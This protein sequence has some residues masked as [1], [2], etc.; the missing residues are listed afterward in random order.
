MHFF[1]T[2][3][4]HFLQSFLPSPENPKDSPTSKTD[5]WK[6][7]SHSQPTVPELEI[8]PTIW[9]SETTKDRVSPY[10]LRGYSDPTQSISSVLSNGWVTKSDS[11]KHGLITR[12]LNKCRETIMYVHAETRANTCLVSKSEMEKG[13]EDI[14]LVWSKN[15]THFHFCL[16]IP[17]SGR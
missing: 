7:M 4:N 8:M 15:V 17:K 13:S 11:D 1:P 14:T 3:G 12:P 5:V 2:S 9:F 16:I 10:P 6:Q